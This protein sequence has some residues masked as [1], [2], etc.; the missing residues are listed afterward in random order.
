[1]E[2]S[3][4]RGWL[5]EGIDAT[6]APL[7][8]RSIATAIEYFVGAPFGSVGTETASG[9]IT[10]A[11]QSTAVK[12]TG[13]SGLMIPIMEDNVLAKRWSEGTFTLDSILAYSAVGA[14]GVD[15]LPLP[16]NVSEEQIAKIV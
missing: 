14:A 8:D 16:G 15:T 1:M 5:Y 6:P 3:K 11:V 2:V 10:R 9:I 13:Y 4:T 7:G 12:R